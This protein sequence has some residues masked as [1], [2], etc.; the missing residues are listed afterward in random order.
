MWKLSGFADE[1]SPDLTAQITTLAAESMHY[2]DLR[3]AWGKNVLALSHDELQTIKTRLAEAGIAI[4][5][6]ASPIGKAPITDDFAQQR[7]AF[8][9]ALEI[10]KRL[11][12]PRIRIFS[13]YLPDGADPATFREEV[14]RRLSAFVKAAEPAGVTLLLENE[15]GLYG[16][17]PSR[18]FDLLM[19]IN[20]A[21]LRAVWDPANYTI[22]GVRPF[23]D[24]FADLRPFIDYVHIKD[25]KLGQHVILPAGQ[26][27]AQIPE[28][29][30]ALHETGF[31]GYI[32]LEPHLA[33]GGAF[34]G[35]SGP[36]QFH[37][38]A[39]VLKQ[40]MLE[41]GIEWE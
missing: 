18:C 33:H 11:E 17:V 41:Q 7:A 37:V 39:S 16:D 13:F 12:V 19:S 34:G 20:S 32:S 6:I 31:D 29:L 5:A 38:A 10:A 36:E 30:A 35:F 2:L 9:G 23:G 26:G 3:G 24:G 21:A 22:L 40:L 27:D 15:I 25:A 4:A 14:I 1:I 28:M 8:T